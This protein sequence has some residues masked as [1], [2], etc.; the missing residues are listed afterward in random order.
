MSI[1]RL[2]AVVILA[3]LI[4][5]VTDWL[6]MG[7][8]FHD[9]YMIHPEVWRGSL[10]EGT[11]IVH[12]ALIAI[13]SCLGFALLAG[14]LRLRTIGSLLAAAFLVWLAVVVPM[15]VQDGIWMKIDPLVLGAHG[16]GWFCRFAI[17]A[18]LCAWLLRPARAE[19]PAA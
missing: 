4:A 11:K 19:P 5:S 9:R 12:S 17:T 18:F 3:S 16:I 2:A 7:A 15:L 14:M 6:F 13:L 1:S 8:M 10:D